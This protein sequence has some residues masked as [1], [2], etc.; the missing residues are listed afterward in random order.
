MNTTA[1]G[2]S[3]GQLKKGFAL[4]GKLGGGATAVAAVISDVLSPLAPFA[5]YLTVALLL[6][7]LLSLAAG[8]VPALSAL[9]GT[10]FGELWQWPVSATLLVSTMIF[11]GTWALGRSTD[12]NTGYLG[13]TVPL[14][15][16]LQQELGMIAEHTRQI[17]ETTKAIQEDTSAIR[18]DTGAIR[19]D[20]GAIRETTAAIDTKMDTLKKETSDDPRKELANRGI[21]WSSAAFVEAMSNGD[22]ES[23]ALFIRGGMRPERLH[24]GV[25]ALLYAL[26]PDAADPAGVLTLLLDHRF[27][28]DTVL[29]DRAIINSDGYLPTYFDHPLKPE[30]Y[31]TWQEPKTFVGPALFWLAQRGAYAGASGKEI[32]AMRVLLARGADTELTRAYLEIM[33]RAWG[34]D[35]TFRQV[36]EVIGQ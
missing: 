4:M 23:T 8:F 12:A 13:A 3:A 19:E 20:T 25:S 34:G 9:C 22:L 7:F 26:T 11:M 32:A 17:A 24:E 33:S 15:G 2:R 30:G 29:T 5:L 31:Q 14:I 6:L 27:D 16:N 35:R 10:W 36:A 28:P 1:Q 18:E 21:P